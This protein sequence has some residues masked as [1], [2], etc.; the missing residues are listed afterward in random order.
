M[1]TP[2]FMSKDFSRTVNAQLKKLGAVIIGATFIPGVDGTFANG[3]RA[4]QLDHN[5]TSIL[6]TYREVLAMVA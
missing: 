5:G 3:E 6:R 1:A 4:Y 2:H